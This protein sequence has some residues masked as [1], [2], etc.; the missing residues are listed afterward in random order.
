MIISGDLLLAKEQYIVHQCN[1]L[2]AHSAGLAQMIFDKF[3][4]SNS[5][6]KR[7]DGSKNIPGT[8]EI[9][10]DGKSQ[11]YVINAY[12][13]VYPGKPKYPNSSLDGTH[14]RLYYFNQC[15]NEIKKIE[16]LQSIAFPYKIGCNMAGGNWQDY[17]QLITSFANDVKAQNITVTIYKK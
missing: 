12:A 3:P 17:L 9:F 11:K 5:Y 1:C 7:Q 6:Q 13:Q 8:I 10:G 15:L 4:Y 16:N 14:K 2:T